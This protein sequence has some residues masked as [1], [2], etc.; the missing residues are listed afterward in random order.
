MKSFRFHFDRT[1]KYNCP[2]CGHKRFSRIIDKH[3]GNLLPDHVGR[4][5]R[6]D[7]CGSY[8]SVSQYLKESGVTLNDNIITVEKP[9]KEREQLF[10]PKGYVEQ[11]L[12]GYEN[13]S[14]AKC[15]LKLFGSD[16]GQEVLSKYK[17]GSSTGK[18]NDGA[19]FWYVDI[20][21]NVH[22]GQVKKFRDDLHTDSYIDKDGESNKCDVSFTTA[23]KAKCR[24]RGESIPDW[25][26]AYELQE[27]KSNCLFGEHLLKE[28]DSTIALCEAPKTAIIAAVYYPQYTWLAVGGKSYLTYERLKVLKGRNIILFPD[29]GAYQLWKEKAKQFSDLATFQISDLLERKGSKG[30]DVG[31]YLIQYDYRDF[32]QASNQLKLHYESGDLNPFQVCRTGSLYDNLLIVAMQ[33]ADGKIIDVLMNESEEFHLEQGSAVKSLSSFY[34]KTFRPGTIDGNNCLINVV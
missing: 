5:D 27:K 11:S 8:Y 34:S 9:Q 17:V 31:D 4:C 33:T 29:N 7:S 24:K 26:K 1:K 6:S 16:L 19:V 14:F 18:W 25:V 10:I 20:S 13:N 21:G 28:S 15:I 30:S 22:R 2:S 32:I 23:L 12:R 3:T